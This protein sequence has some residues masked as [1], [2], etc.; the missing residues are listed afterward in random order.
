MAPPI[1]PTA[2]VAPAELLDVYLPEALAAFAEIE[3]AEDLDGSLGLQLVGESGGEWVLELVGGRLRVR[4]GS[5]AET[6]LS[7]VQSVE[8]WRAALWQGRGA[9][10][11]RAIARMFRAAPAP[12]APPRSLAPAARAS[13]DALRKLDGLLRVAV[14]EPGEGAWHAD[15]RLG[16]GDLPRRPTTTVSLRGRDADRLLTGRLNPLEAYLAGKVRLSGDYGLLLQ[17]HAAGREVG[18]AFGGGRG[19]A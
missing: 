4:P 18:G 15:L 9:G 12:S 19:R 17:L 3:G 1:F 7:F 14:A 6:P 5:R 13:L 11:G 2:P 8:H 10:I 16:P